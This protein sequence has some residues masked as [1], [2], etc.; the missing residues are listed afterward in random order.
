MKK[1]YTKKG[2][3][4]DYDPNDPDLVA[5]E[6]ETSLDDYEAYP[7]ETKQRAFP[8]LASRINTRRAIRELVLP[9]ITAIAATLERIEERLDAIEGSIGDG[10]C[11][12]ELH[13]R[14]TEA[15]VSEHGG[16]SGLGCPHGHVTLPRVQD[17]V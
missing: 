3:K 17:R 13:E 8:V 6:L 7:T 4:P 15:A 9:E 12:F 14:L 10:A 5:A 16:T 1:P 11:P 2:Q